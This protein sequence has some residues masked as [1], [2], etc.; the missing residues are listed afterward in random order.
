M[1]LALLAGATVFGAIFALAAALHVSGGAIQAGSD[2]DL[3]CDEDG[4]RVLEWN[5]D[6]NTGLV[7]SVRIG[8]IDEG[9]QQGDTDLF[10]VLTHY[11]FKLVGGRYDNLDSED[12]TVPLDFP[13]SAWNITD[14]EVFI[15]GEA[16]D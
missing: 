3:A 15:E 4:V 9:C 14:I 13:M 6:T 5:L 12:V 10:V 8:D 1:A 7:S 16:N 2:A 11:G